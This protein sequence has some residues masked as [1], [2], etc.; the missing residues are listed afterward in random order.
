MTNPIYQCEHCFS[1]FNELE[2]QQ[3]LKL[4][5]KHLEQ[6]RPSPTMDPF[7][8]DMEYQKTIYWHLKQLLRNHR[9][10]RRPLNNMMEAQQMP[11]ES[12]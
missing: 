5:E 4:L 3:L 7:Y 1:K 9:R 6:D 8:D 11:P 12:E 2:V 10:A